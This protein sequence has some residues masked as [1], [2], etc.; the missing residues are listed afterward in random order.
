[1]KVAVI[2]E[3]GTNFTELDK[4]LSGAG[5]QAVR[6]TRAYPSLMETTLSFSSTA[7]ENVYQV[8]VS[9]EPLKEFINCSLPKVWLNWADKEGRERAWVKESVEIG[10]PI[11]AH[12]EPLLADL[13]DAVDGVWHFECNHL[14]KD[15]SVTMVYVEELSDYSE[16]VKER[17][18]L[19]LED[20]RSNFS[21]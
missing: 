11:K 13:L 7:R 1:M 6:Y 8:S 19:A 17:V 2:A 20:Y 16:A 21:G 4:I 9:D 10:K 3:L 14:P 18:N 12:H 15:E 5:I